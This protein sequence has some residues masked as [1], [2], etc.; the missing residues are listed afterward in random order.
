MVKAGKLLILLND[1][2]ELL[3]GGGSGPEFDELGRYSL[4]D[5]ADRAQRAIS[6]NRL[7]VKDDDSL[8]LWTV[9]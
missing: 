2:A 1:D 5:S 4:A 7:F 6:G 3:V 9:E 8:A